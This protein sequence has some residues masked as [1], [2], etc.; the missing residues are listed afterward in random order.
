MGLNININIY[1]NL[2]IINRAGSFEK[3]TIQLLLYTHK[4]LLKTD[5]VII[6]D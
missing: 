3:Q 5:K 2:Q 6:K 1:Q 4:K